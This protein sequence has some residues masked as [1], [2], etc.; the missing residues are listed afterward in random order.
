M[1]HRATNGWL[2]TH[3]RTE[4]EELMA[5]WLESMLARNLAP[6]TLTIYRLEVGQFLRFLETLGIAT[7]EAVKPLHIRKWLAFRRQQGVSARQLRNDWQ[8]PATFFRW[9]QR[10]GLVNEN[11]IDQV[12]KP[13]CPV[14]AKPPLTPEAIQRIMNACDGQHWTRL[15]DKALAMLLL[16]TGLRIREAYTLKIADAKQDCLFIRGKGGKQR[17]VFLSPETRLALKRYLKALP[18]PVSDESPL[19]WGTK[20]A[21]TL[22]GLMEVVEKMG[23][24]AGLPKH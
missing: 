7:P 11:P 6:K 23:K 21:L 14:Q 22:W 12:E 24:R 9:L 10:E 17:M 20:G 1:T 2:Q 19:W 18:Y 13:K 4:L 5:L 3:H 15:R 16:D 8:S